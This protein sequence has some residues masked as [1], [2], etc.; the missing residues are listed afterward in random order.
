M[1]PVG[2]IVNP[3][4][5]KDIRRLGACGSVFYNHEKVDIVRRVILGLDSM[6]VQ[7]V[8]F[9]PDHFG[10][11]TRAMQDLEVTLKTSFL[12]MAM[13]GAQDDST[14]AAEMLNKMGAVCIIT[15]GGDGTNRAVAKACGDMPLLSIS[16]GTN[17]VFPFIN[18]HHKGIRGVLSPGRN[19]LDPPGF[20]ALRLPDTARGREDRIWKEIK[21]SGAK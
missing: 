20:C 14:R 9:I 5:G 19:R 1:K 2:I 12:E 13:E 8:L 18:G 3:A 15:L 11:G 16:I 17:N 21:V 10:I 7:E 4:S 6:G